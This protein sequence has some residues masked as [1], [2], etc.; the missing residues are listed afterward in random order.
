MRWVMRL[1]NF[2]VFFLKFSKSISKKQ[3]WDCDLRSIQ[4]MQYTGQYPY[5]KTCN[6]KVQIFSKELLHSPTY[7]SLPCLSKVPSKQRTIFISIYRNVM[8]QLVEGLLH[9]ALKE[10]YSSCFEVFKVI[11]TQEL[12]VNNDY[13]VFFQYR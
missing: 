2:F 11:H 13:Y 3:R 5:I 10:E 6:C 4:G 7:A 9:F 8:Q 12:L 1:P